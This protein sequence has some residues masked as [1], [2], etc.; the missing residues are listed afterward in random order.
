MTTDVADAARS[1]IDEIAVPVRVGLAVA[2]LGAAA[3]HFAH[4][5]HHAELSGWQGA[6]FAVVAWAQA[7]WALAVVL[8]PQRWVLV[9]GAVGNA[10]V[11][12]VWVL[13][14]TAGVPVGPD[15]WTAEPVAWYDATATACA[16][17]VVL[18]CGLL[19]AG[20]VPRPSPQLAA[21]GLGVLGATVAL[22]TSL[23]LVPSVAGEHEHDEP[24]HHGGPATAAGHGDHEAMAST[25]AAGGGEHA[26][27][28]PALEPLT[29]QERTTLGQELVQ[30]RTVALRYPLASDA[31]AAG[32]VPAGPTGKGS[33]AHYVRTDLAGETDLDIEA[34]MSLLYEDVRPDA[35]IVGVM[36]YSA[37]DAAPEGFTGPNDHWHRHAGACFRLDGDRIHVPFRVDADVTADQCAGVEGAEFID[38]TGWMLHVWVAP[39]WESPH[40]VFS[41]DNPVIDCP[42]GTSDTGNLGTGCQPV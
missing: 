5:G 21:G 3:I 35:P 42:P 34:P 37:A 11:V 19:L 33:G 17:V 7:L 28:A 16:V 30:A 18:G 31:E 9:A 2:S 38:R 12:A 29:A 20:R 32:Y 41:H 1:G 8:R 23:V 25:A 26:H 14:R 36:Y 27:E 22:A 6:F 24:G 15:P 40:G 10:G 13:A 39:G 4:I